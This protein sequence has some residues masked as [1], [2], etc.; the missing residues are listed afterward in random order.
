MTAVCQFILL[1]SGLS[2]VRGSLLCIPWWTRTPSSSSRACPRLPHRLDVFPR[3]ALLGLVDEL[4]L[5][6][7][8]HVGDV[9]AMAFEARHGPDLQVLPHPLAVLR[10]VEHVVAHS[11][12]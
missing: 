9:P 8:H 2:S 4:E 1:M 11:V 7:P 5:H 10:Q 12:L 6:R 3:L